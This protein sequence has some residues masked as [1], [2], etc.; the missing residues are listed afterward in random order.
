VFDL[1]DPNV[2]TSV[3]WYPV[4]RVSVAIVETMRSASC[5]TLFVILENFSHKELVAFT[6]VTRTVL[7]VDT[8][9]AFTFVVITVSDC[10]AGLMGK[11]IKAH[12]LILITNF[13][14]V[15]HNGGCVGSFVIVIDVN[16]LVAR[17]QFFD[18]VTYVRI[19]YYS[20]IIISYNLKFNYSIDKHL[21][22]T[23]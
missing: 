2:V 12:K 16:A 18:E 10:A 17:V 14:V 19:L 20:S 3:F 13:S 5:E 22:L 11:V 15:L 1:V 7:L 21:T 8:F 4:V 23:I 9:L 6:H